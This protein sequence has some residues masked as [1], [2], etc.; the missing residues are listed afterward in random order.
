MAR[1]I[2]IVEVGP[3]DGLQSE[4]EVLPTA[5]KLEL[6]NRLVAAG[7]KRLEVASF[8]NP[9]RVPQMADAEAVLAGL[10]KVPGV[11]YVGLVLNKKGFDRAL[12]AGCTEVGL[13]TAATNSFSE[14]NQ[15]ATTEE[16]IRTI[17][18][19]APLAREAGVRM[20]VTLSTAFGCPFEGEV[21]A[22]RVVEICQRL[23]QS[24]PLEIA[25]ADTIGVAVPSQVT[26][27]IE[28]V[29]GVVGDVAIRCH[30]H[31]TRNTA[32]ANAYAAVLA[33]VSTLD[34]SVGGVGGCPFA[35]NATG[36]V[37]TE[38]L[39]YMLSRAG[40]DT[41]IDL[42]KLIDTARWLGEQRGKPV[43]SMVSK[44][45]G[46]PVVTAGASA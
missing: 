10:P 8:V 2:E 28:Q 4:P 43:P 19:I 21:P 6:I 42:T 3:R 13:V 7:L 40:Y 30:F 25:L 17:E 33:G 34:A 32:V 46:F 11:Q 37:G 26:A 39:V 1:A 36:N 22:A 16:L 27:L 18:E 45:G 5:T 9:K 44:A 38:D 24:K 15:G 12:A 41:G 29:R 23:A 14:R 31:N 20:Q 35:P